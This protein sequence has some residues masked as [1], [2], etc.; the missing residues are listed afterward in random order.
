M[1]GPVTPIKIRALQDLLSLKKKDAA[2][3]E[4]REMRTIT[5]QESLTLLLE[6][7]VELSDNRNLIANSNAVQERAL[8]AESV[9]YRKVAELVDQIEVVESEINEYDIEVAGTSHW[10]CCNS[11]L[12]LQLVDSAAVRAEM[13]VTGKSNELLQYERTVI[14]VKWRHL[15]CQMLLRLQ[16]LADKSTQ[17]GIFSF[18]L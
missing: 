13:A 17:G 15:T 3:S 18:V 11:I 9:D 8:I 14:F 16:V 2:M 6:Q 5:L 1:H 12:W 7:K 10:T 4:E